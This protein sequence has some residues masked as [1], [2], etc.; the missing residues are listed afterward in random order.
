M[1]EG[2]RGEH[3]Q[4]SNGDGAR[5]AGPEH[6]KRN[7]FIA[8]FGINIGFSQHSV[9]FNLQ[10]IIIILLFTFFGISVFE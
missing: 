1:I 10:S 2:K 9:H 7:A 6:I 3:T 8:L 4:A 5:G